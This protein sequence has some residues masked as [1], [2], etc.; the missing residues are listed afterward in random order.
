M[1]RWLYVV[2]DLVAVG[3]LGF[4]IYFPRYRRRDLL[5]SY[6]S[7]NVGVMA[8][9][10]ALTSS[11]AGVGIGVGFGLFG[12]LSIVRLRSD[13]LAQQELAYYFIALALGLLGGLEISPWWLVPILSAAIVAAPAVGDHPRLFGA[14]RHQKMILDHAF[15]DEAALR[16]HLERLLDADV[17]H[18]LVMRT[19]L[20]NDTTAVDVRYRLRP[21]RP[22]DGTAS[23]AGRGP[24]DVS[25][26][27]A[28]PSPRPR[29]A[30]PQLRAN[31]SGPEPTRLPG[32]PPA[33]TTRPAAEAPVKPIPAP[34]ATRTRPRPP[35]AVPDGRAAPAPTG[36]RENGP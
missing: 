10:V 6:L 2:C 22:R 1:P 16:R 29:P 15:T 7:V 35:A 26:R 13:E 34:V 8:V 30:A 20:V 36:D 32:R 31:G 21:P 33:G 11:I 12:V 9:V 4:A 24:A 18:L 17:K 28:G 19:D 27:H 23:D 25:P 5:V 3:L 14:H